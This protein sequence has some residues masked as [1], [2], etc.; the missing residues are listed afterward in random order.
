MRH[1][2]RGKVSQKQVTESEAAPVPIIRIPTKTLI[3][4]TITYMQRAYVSYKGS[5]VAAL[6][7]VSLDGPCLIVS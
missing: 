1:P 5:V 2:G 4:T 3:Y 7:S 6:V